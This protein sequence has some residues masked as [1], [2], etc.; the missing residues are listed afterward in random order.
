M[1]A[2]GTRIGTV[3]YEIEPDIDFARFAAAGRMVG[4]TLGNSFRNSL[5]PGVRR[6]YDEV[7]RTV[8]AQFK[9]FEADQA[10]LTKVTQGAASELG[11]QYGQS[12]SIL[13]KGAND[14]LKQ[15]GAAA[16]EA[17][18]RWAGIGQAGSSAFS[19]IS[20]AASTAGSTIFH[21]ME[22]ASGAIR[23]LSSHIGIA[24]FQMQILGSALT[25]VVTGPL[26]AAG[27]GLSKWGLGTAMDIEDAQVALTAI[28]PVG[29]DVLA[30]VDRLQAFA[31][32]SP[33]FAVDEL[34]NFTRKLVGAG[35]EASHAEKI[36]D[37]LNKVFITYGV[38]G[39]K[40]SKA[41]LGVSQ[42]FSKGKVQAE[43]LTGQI[44][45]Q[46][47]IWNLLS[48]VSG[49]A[50]GDLMK[51]SK[52]GDFSAELF[53]RWIAQVGDIPSISQGAAQGVHTL[54][55]QFSILKESIQQAIAVKL[56]EYFPQIK[57]ALADILPVLQELLG[58]FLEKIPVAIEWLG[59]FA[60][61]ILWLREKFNE[62]NPSQKEWIERILKLAPVI[63]PVLLALGTMATAL[64]GILGA[65][66]MLLNPWGLLI[67]VIVGGLAAL[68]IKFQA[69][70]DVVSG[71]VEAVW[72][73]FKERV[74]PALQELWLIVQ[75]KLIPAYEKLIKALGFDS[76]KEFGT[77]IGGA[78]IGAIVAI[79]KV[80]GF[81]IEVWAALI[82]D[83]S[84]V[85]SALKDVWKWVVDV[86]SAISNFISGAGTAIG[87]FF[88]N[89]W[90]TITS[91]ISTAWHKVLDFFG[92]IVQNFKE[93]V[94]REMDKALGQA[95]I[96]AF[97]TV[98]GIVLVSFGW[99][100]DTTTSVFG[101][102]GRFIADAWS[103]VGKSIS[104][105]SDNI[106]Q[107]VFRVLSGAVTWLADHFMWFANG[108]IRPIWDW[109]GEKIHSV[110]DFIGRIWDGLK[111]KLKAPVNIVIGFINSGIIDSWNRLAGVIPFMPTISRIP[112][113]ATGGFIQGPGT[114]ISDSILALLSNGEFVATAAATSLYRSTL[115]A[116]NSG[117]SPQVV[118]ATLPTT[119]G[120]SSMTRGGDGAQQPLYVSVLLDG[121]PIVERAQAVVDAN[122]TATINTYRAMRRPA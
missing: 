12:F 102:I 92:G 34:F 58:L 24:S 122:N 47:P 20:S 54:S 63:G 112:A 7:S 116:M 84:Y 23:S 61:G 67:G 89:L 4:D 75:Q 93:Y 5:T 51:M 29:Y 13:S 104:W 3:Y 110:V 85:V 38:T 73:G 46:I 108:V 71:F 88:A 40:A 50:Q 33:V 115:E 35:V 70:R 39:E 90:S 25:A 79:I 19:S 6:A 86:G 64:S 36:L 37:S 15:S 28:L 21:G 107:P 22:T 60:K 95:F 65:V 42:V 94:A 109:I 80:V 68:Y 103:N 72:A 41:L 96:N 59:K 27:I 118:R 101:T 117:A 14:L 26:L 82:T 106:I 8:N 81:L 98:K 10:N 44:G 49:Q 120:L 111:D 100:W 121:Q 83:L 43:E 1:T 56:L 97:E 66:S 48:Q 16:H 9:R 52:S 57:Q 113:L 77:F 31:V 74:W 17:G 78:L 114:G 45:E 62:L 55:A 76:W 30:L 119:N 91:G 2:P 53:S 11:K 87:S 69:V 99:L 18:S 105:V 32:K